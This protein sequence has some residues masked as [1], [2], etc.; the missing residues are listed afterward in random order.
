MIKAK[1]QIINITVQ[2]VLPIIGSISNPRK[3]NTA[4]HAS[5]PHIIIHPTFS[6]NKNP[7]C[8]AFG[9]VDL[10]LDSV[11]CAANRLSLDAL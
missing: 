11:N 6:N 9:N 2:S 8:I 7:L 1:I 10:H 4:I 5:N 3:Q